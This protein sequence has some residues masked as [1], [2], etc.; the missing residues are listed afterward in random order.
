VIESRLRNRAAVLVVH[1]RWPRVEARLSTVESA[2]NGPTAGVGQLDRRQA[3]VLVHRGARP[4]ERVELS[5][6]GVHRVDRVD[7][8]PGARTHAARRAIG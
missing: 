1:G 3:G 2:W 8:R 6:P 7:R 4:P 5:W